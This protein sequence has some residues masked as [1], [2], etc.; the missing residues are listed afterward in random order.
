MTD[1][2]FSFTDPVCGC[3]RDSGHRCKPAWVHPSEW[4]IPAGTLE[5]GVLSESKGR[6]GTETPRQGLNAPDLAG[7]SAPDATGGTTG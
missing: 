5:N 2:M 6:P 4:D 1:G 7:H 3:P